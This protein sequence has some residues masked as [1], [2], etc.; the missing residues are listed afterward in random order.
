MFM[1]HEDLRT[2]RGLPRLC[3][4]LGLRPLEGL[5]QAELSLRPALKSAG[6][7]PYTTLKVNRKTI[8]FVVPVTLVKLWSVVIFRFPAQGCTWGA[9]APFSV[10]LPL[11]TLEHLIVRGI[12]KAVC[13]A[14]I[15]YLS[16]VTS[17]KLL[18]Q[19]LSWIFYKMST[20]ITWVSAQWFPYKS[21]FLLP[22]CATS[23]LSI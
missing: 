13:S 11:K 6:S 8:S 17:L 1:Y 19:L 22:V 9:A 16:Q 10:L 18:S 4:G 3:L 14:N 20:G 7:F 12:V 23:F 15:L 2:R 21:Y 5:L